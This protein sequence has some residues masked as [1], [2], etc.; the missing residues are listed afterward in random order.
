MFVV[1]VVD[2]A[3][4][5][6]L[7]PNRLRTSI[8]L[9]EVEISRSEQRV[10]KQTNKNLRCKI[11]CRNRALFIRQDDDHHTHIEHHG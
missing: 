4:P 3:H 10:N 2:A 1:V 9:H 6:C 8:R 5:I 7:G 11:T